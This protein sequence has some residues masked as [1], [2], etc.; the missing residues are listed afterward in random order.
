MKFFLSFIS[1]TKVFVLS[2]FITDRTLARYKHKNDCIVIGNGPSLNES[3][4]KYEQILKNHD[5][6]CVNSFASSNYF[7]LIKPKYYILGAEILFL[8][9][10]LLSPFY[11]NHRNQI[12]DQIEHNTTWKMFLFVPYSAKK[13]IFFN[14]FIIKNKF[15]TPVF[16]N[17]VGV[18]GFTLI[19]RFFFNLKLGIPRPHNILIP[20]LMNVIHLG[21][22]RIYIIGADH[23]WLSEISVDI[24]N[25]ALVNQ[26]HFYDENQ[27]K[28]EK[29]ED[30]IKRPRKLHEIIHKFYLSFKGYW[31]I[32]NYA[33]YKKVNIYNAS[34][35]SMIDAFER[36]K[37][38]KI[39]EINER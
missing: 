31:D 37:L 10:K 6:I 29:M 8:E 32:K 7:T 33:D 36:R 5:V 26:K 35:V 13:S 4:E 14:D 34:E 25:N 20:A 27:T 11:I 3:L 28:P 39:N 19:N 17:N 16:F 12:F 30:Y 22:K 18:E 38:S 24:N 1:L 2:K 15:I 21:Y 23:S 9:E